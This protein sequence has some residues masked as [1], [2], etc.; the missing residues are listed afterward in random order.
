MSGHSAV[1]HRGGTVRSRE[2]FAGVVLPVRHIRW[3]QTVLGG[4]DAETDT[5]TCTAACRMTPEPMVPTF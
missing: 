2:L 1:R 5:I 3:S 4:F